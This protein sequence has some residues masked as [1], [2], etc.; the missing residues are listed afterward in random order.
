MTSSQTLHI[1][2]SI[3]AQACQII[4]GLLIKSIQQRDSLVNFLCVR[5]IN[6]NPAP[7][8]QFQPIAARVRG[9]L[10]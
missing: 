10:T 4:R 3:S 5:A 1:K 6:D 7:L 8:H 9:T 2:L